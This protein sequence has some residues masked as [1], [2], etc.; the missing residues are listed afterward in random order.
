[1]GTAH[2]VLLQET[3]AHAINAP[4]RR[5]LAAF[6]GSPQAARA[7]AEAIAL[8]YTHNARLTVVTV[9]PRCYPWAYGASQ[10]G[11]TVELVESSVGLERTYERILETAVSSVPDDI[12]VTSL[13]KRGEPGPVIVDEAS[14]GSYDLVVMGSRGRG[15]LRSL[16]LGSV[17]HH[18][19]R[20]SPVPVLIVP[21][22]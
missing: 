7:L 1:M 22:C 12:S 9:A 19:L 4:Y 2:S 21:P 20:S 8:S 5:L 14:N 13:L 11:A 17:S 15:E 3:P 6:D 16:L 18:V 10:Y